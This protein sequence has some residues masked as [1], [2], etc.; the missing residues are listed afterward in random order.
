MIENLGA[1]GK[2]NEMQLKETKSAIERS[3]SDQKVESMDQHNSKL[4][5]LVKDKKFYFSESID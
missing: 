2:E 3:M 4:E 5:E 1:N